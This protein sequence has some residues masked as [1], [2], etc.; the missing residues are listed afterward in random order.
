MRTPASD[1]AA[2]NHSDVL[3]KAKMST[4][5]LMKEVLQS[6]GI[7]RDLLMEKTSWDNLEESISKDILEEKTSRDIL[8]EKISKNILKEKTSKDANTT[9]SPLPC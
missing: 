4:S 5:T 7:P 3:D 2:R 9:R 8:E 6:V 1:V